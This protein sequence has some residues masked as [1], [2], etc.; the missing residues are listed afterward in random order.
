MVRLASRGM[1]QHIRSALR[2][3]LHVC[4]SQPA[5]EEMAKRLAQATTPV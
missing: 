3:V 1:R 4:L 2:C 5:E